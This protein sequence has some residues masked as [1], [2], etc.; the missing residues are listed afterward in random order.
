MSRGSDSH[1]MSAMAGSKEMGHSQNAM[2][3]SA[4]RLVMRV[5]SVK[6][7]YVIGGLGLSTCGGMPSARVQDVHGY[8]RLRHDQW[9]LSTE[10]GHWPTQCAPREGRP[11]QRTKVGDGTRTCVEKYG[12]SVA[13]SPRRLQSRAF[14]TQKPPL[15]QLRIL[16]I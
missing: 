14:V 15:V 5:M 4:L 10:S 11:L 7:V 12:T 2:V 16:G 9:G 8:L 13:R 3:G 6:N 1:T